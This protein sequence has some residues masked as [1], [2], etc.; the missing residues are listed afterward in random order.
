M[1][2]PSIALGN[3]YE[4]GDAIEDTYTIMHDVL[5]AHRRMRAA[6]HRQKATLKET[7]ERL[8]EDIRDGH[9]LPPA[10]HRERLR[11]IAHISELIYWLE[12]S[13]EALDN[14]I[15]ILD[16]PPRSATPPVEPDTENAG[17]A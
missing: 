4:A 7:R 14:A 13:E 12:Q 1:A 9:A 6:I 5:G 10:T 11:R 8:T 16:S 3:I 2:I 15:C 17:S